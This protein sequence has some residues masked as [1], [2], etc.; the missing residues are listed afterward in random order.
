[1]GLVQNLLRKK[2]GGE[3]EEWVEEGGRR[4]RGVLG[5]AGLGM[6]AVVEGL[7]EGDGGTVRRG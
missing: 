5:G 7:D 6:G 1:M 3:A 4:G 2:L